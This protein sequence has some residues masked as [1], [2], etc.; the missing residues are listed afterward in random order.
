MKLH[1]FLSK[2][3]EG[4]PVNVYL[5]DGDFVGQWQSGKGDFMVD[6]WGPAKISS[7]SNMVLSN[8]E[9]C[10]QVFLEDDE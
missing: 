6:D 10:I 1:K 3:N 8:G 2:V 7:I 5:C 9:P 4:Y